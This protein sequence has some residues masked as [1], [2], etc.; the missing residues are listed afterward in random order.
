[1]A[2]VA[3]FFFLVIP[4]YLFR[5]FYFHGEFSKQLSFSTNGLINLLVSFFTGI[6]L[7]FVVISL[8][9][10]STS[11][12]INLDQLLS[13]FDDNLLDDTTSTNGNSFD[14]FSN[15]I[16]TKFLPFIGLLY[17]VSALFGFAISRLITYLNLDTKNKVLRFRNDWY[18]LFSGRCFKFSRIN[19]S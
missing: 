1:Y 5:R 19:K 3:L 15:K 6:V 9:N 7:L 17:S 13:D 18:Y 4:G 2:I 12:T 14:G 8:W 11:L 10:Y 16:R